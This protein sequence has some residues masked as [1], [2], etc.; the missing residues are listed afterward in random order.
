MIQYTPLFSKLTRNIK[1]ETVTFDQPLYYKAREI[2]ECR[3]HELTS[4]NVRLSGFHLLI[5]F[6]SAI[7]FIMDDSGRKEIF[8]ETYAQTSVDNITTGHAYARPVR[9]HILAHTALS[10][11]I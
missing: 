1:K 2:L 10:D 6:T 11:I 8:S 9:A 3:S 4:V 7:A 5:S